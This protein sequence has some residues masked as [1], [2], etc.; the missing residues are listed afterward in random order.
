MKF[1]RS[2]YNISYCRWPAYIGPMSGHAANRPGDLHTN[3]NAANNDDMITFNPAVVHRHGPDDP[4]RSRSVLFKPG[5]PI[6][7]GILEKE[8]E[9]SFKWRIN[10][11][12]TTGYVARSRVGV[13]LAAI[14]ASFR[15]TPLPE[16]SKYDLF[17]TN[18]EHFAKWCFHGEKQ[19]PTS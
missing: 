11:Q 12:L 16:F 9:V 15:V 8:I 13:L 17:H 10:N 7:L 6:S 3:N 1:E 18:C 4:D 19:S 5:F 2:C 14:L